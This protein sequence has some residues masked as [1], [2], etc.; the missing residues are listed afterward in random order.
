MDLKTIKIKEKTHHKLSMYKVKNKLKSLDEA[1][2]K[3]LK[4]I[5]NGI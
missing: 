2:N 1:I 4:E 3:L 5:K